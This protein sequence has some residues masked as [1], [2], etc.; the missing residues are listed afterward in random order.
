MNTFPQIKAVPGDRKLS[1]SPELNF[2]FGFETQMF[3]GVDWFPW[4]TYVT[5][6][7][8]LGAKRVDMMLTLVCCEIR[9][10]VAGR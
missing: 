7:F 6:D 10:H 1:T 4:G 8:Y 9:G 3:H 5:L 2:V